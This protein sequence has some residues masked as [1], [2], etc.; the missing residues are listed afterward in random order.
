MGPA[1]PILA[2][3]GLAI[4]LGVLVAA[5]APAGGYI[6]AVAA[7]VCG[8]ATWVLPLLGAASWWYAERRR[9]PRKLPSLAVV[10]HVMVILVLAAMPTVAGTLLAIIA[11]VSAEGASWAWSGLATIATFWVS[12]AIGGH[13][14]S[15]GSKPAKP[16]PP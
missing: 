11:L 8:F 14:I 2:A 3:A 13:F 1:K 6:V 4:V 16:R 10:G 7:G 9:R 15:R 5:V 12:V